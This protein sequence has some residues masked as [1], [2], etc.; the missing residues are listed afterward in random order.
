VSDTTRVPFR[1]LITASAMLAML[2]QTLDST[3]ANVA[4]PYMQGSMSASA[5]E[6]TWVLTSYVIAAAIMTAPVGWM[7]RRFGRKKLFIGCLIGFTVTSMLCGAAQTLDQLVIFRLLQ[8]MCGAAIA[9]LSQATMLDI[10]PFSKRAQAMALFSMGVT[11]GPIMGP[12]F[13][14]WLTDA[15]SWRF[16]FYVNLP[17]GIL[18]IL[19]LMIFMRETPS[20]TGMRFSWYGFSMLALGCGALQLMLDRGQE[21]DW[22]AS[23]EIM[24]YAALAGLGFYL[25]VVHMFLAEKP[26]LAL[27]LFKDRN[28][29]SG[30][31]M[32]FCVSSVMLA[33]SALLAPYLQNLAGYPVYTAGWAMAPR[34]IGTMLSMFLASR[35]GMRFDQR[36][37][38][39]CGLLT[40]G[41]ALYEMSTWTPDVTEQQMMLT[42]VLQGFSIGL[43]FNPMTVMAYTTLSPQLRGEGTA[44]QSLAR[45]IGSSIGISV[46]SFT[47]IRGAQT[48][49]AEIAAGITPFNRVLQMGDYVSRTLNPETTHGAA[50]LDDMIN[51]QARI[52]AYNNDFR[53]MTLTIV[54]PM[55]LLLF[56]R[57]HVR[58]VARPPSP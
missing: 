55:V 4:L 6:I 44:L 42:L 20:Q 28:F 46:T 49:H 31:V 40:L 35:L 53:L 8:G 22:F 16:V 33:T 39:A 30:M 43:V 5:D 10:Y 51:H 57:R 52:I 3:I 36:K 45:N 7:A 15:Y 11:M 18:A 32:V 2:M 48:T 54:P 26:F 27:A 56:M 17:F 34:G 12:T 25:F 19:G 58:P 1:G 23:R 50:L 47:L 38:M 14:G 29:S 24:T 41:W 37:I 13:G 21:M 9:P